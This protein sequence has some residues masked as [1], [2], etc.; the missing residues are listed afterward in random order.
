MLS[1]FSFSDS[2]NLAAGYA[3]YLKLSNIVNDPP[4][5]GRMTSR[6]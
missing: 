2:Q 1:N 4:G 5:R 6:S 3:G